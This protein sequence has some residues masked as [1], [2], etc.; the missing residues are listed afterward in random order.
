V[1]LRRTLE[2]RPGV[3]RAARG[4]DAVVHAC[5]SV[6]P[7]APM[8]LATI[9]LDDESVR[10]RLQEWYDALVD[11]LAR[12]EG[13]QEWSV[14]VFAHAPTR[15]T[16]EAAAEPAVMGGAA[17]LRR[18]KAL[19]EERRAAEAKALAAAEQVD[20]ALRDLAVATRRLR[21]QDPRLSGAAGTM[22]LNGAYLVDASYANAFADRVA[23]LGAEHP[24]VSVACGGPWPPYSFAT[25]DQS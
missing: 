20:L 11:A 14:K 4:H 24:E 19:G 12:V 1:G 15:T 7:T 21:P 2:Q 5:A 16:T 13:R 18:K 22:L 6:A 3:D 23:A 8:R 25:L 10:R 17:Y 9:C